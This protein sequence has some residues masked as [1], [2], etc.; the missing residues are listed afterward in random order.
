MSQNLHPY[1]RRHPQQ[2]RT[3]AILML[4]VSPILLPMILLAAHW[5]EI[6]GEFASCYREIWKCASP[7]LNAKG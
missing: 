3:V 2:M 6:C 7:T 5:E 4:I 1:W